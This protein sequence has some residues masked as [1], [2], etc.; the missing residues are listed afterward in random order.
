M[1]TQTDW[2][3]LTRYVAG[4]CTASEAADIESRLAADESL[5]SLHHHI[6]EVWEATVSPELPVDTEAAWK[7]QQ[8]QSRRPEPER[9]TSRPPVSFRPRRRSA[10]WPVA[11]LV[12]A[13]LLVGP[14]AYRS[15]NPAAPAETHPEITGFVTAQ[16]ERMTVQLSDGTRVKLNVDSRLRVPVRF[17]SDRR[18]VVLEGEAYFDVAPDSRRPFVIHAGGGRVRVLGTVFNVRA[19]PEE[20]VEVAV[21]EGLVS[22]G[23]DPDTETE[24]VTD[25]VLLRANQLGRLKGAELTVRPGIDLQRYLGWTRNRLVFHEA[26]FAE[27]A[28]ELER[29]YDLEVVLAQPDIPLTT[30]D[31]SFDDVPVGEVLR[32][33]AATLNLE[34][35]RNGR[36][37]VFR[38]VVS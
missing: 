27:V 20:S 23:A 5:R 11:A 34:Y 31:A 13:L 17:A 2:K 1:N 30:L 37:V 9:R 33:I 14:W 38:P 28:R 29:W 15:L 25:S 7:R 3:R 24:T 4:E 19:Y 36:R 16:G 21:E 26:P 32:V 35:E 10:L 8:Y 6:R 18:E 22:L 12:L